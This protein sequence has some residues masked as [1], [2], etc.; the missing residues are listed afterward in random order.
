MSPADLLPYFCRCVLFDVNISVTGDLFV[1]MTQRDDVDEKRDEYTDERI[2]YAVEGE[3]GDA[4]IGA[5]CDGDGKESD[6]GDVGQCAFAHEIGQKKQWCDREQFFQ[7][8]FFKDSRERIILDGFRDVHQREN[9]ERDQQI[10]QRRQPED[11]EF[12]DDEKN[13]HTGKT[14]DQRADSPVHADTECASDFRLQT[15]DRCD[16]GIKRNA[17]SDIEELVNQAT[18]EDRQRCLDDQLSHKQKISGRCFQSMS[19]TN[20]L[21]DNGKTVQRKIGS[22]FSKYEG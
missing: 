8:S 12:P 21:A 15:D 19:G 5:V 2:E 16:A 17:G 6:A 4:G 9:A 22:N 14:A 18:D 3:A 1:R 10:L 11:T 13:G 20:S 7:V